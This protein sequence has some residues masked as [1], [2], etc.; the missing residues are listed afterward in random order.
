MYA[1][2]LVPRQKL[3]MTASITLRTRVQ[4]RVITSVR[5]GKDTTN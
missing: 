5:L 4:K 3:L 1:A 2:N